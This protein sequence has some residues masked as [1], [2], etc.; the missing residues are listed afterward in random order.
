[1]AAAI[2]METAASEAAPQ[3][4]GFDELPRFLL[5]GDFTALNVL[6]RRGLPAAVIDFDLCHIG[7]RPWEFA[8]A[9][10]YK[11]PGMLEG[12]REEAARL[13][14]GLT[15][16]ELRAIPAVYRAFRAGMIRW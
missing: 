14:I 4:V 13:G 8:I 3:G 1:L 7:T 10:L 16:E 15:P 12:Y 6:Q 2:E 11:A 5:H 9:R